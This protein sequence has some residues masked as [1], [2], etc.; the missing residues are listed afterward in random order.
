VT[1]G[2]A[3]VRMTGSGPKDWN[4]GPKDWSKSEGPEQNPKD[5]SG[6]LKVRSKGGVGGQSLTEQSKGWRIR[7]KQTDKRERTE[8]LN[9]SEEM[10]LNIRNAE[11]C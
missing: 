7:K 5:R 8:R 1:E 2:R 10:R 4:G 9:D 11:P 3:R 6:S